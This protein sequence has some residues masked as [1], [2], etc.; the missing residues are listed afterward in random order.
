[1]RGG[2]ALIFRMGGGET[3]KRGA[4]GARGTFAI[5]FHQRS[6]VL[7]AAK[8]EVPG[9]CQQSQQRES[10]ESPVPKQADQGTRDRAGVGHRQP[11]C[12]T[13]PDADSPPWSWKR[14]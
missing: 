9:D 6:Y 14:R 10:G 1:M 4:A 7:S 13:T 3:L 5:G 12:A 11:S 8:R 2:S